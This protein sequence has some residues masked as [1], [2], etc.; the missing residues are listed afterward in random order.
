[1]AH[2]EI[3]TILYL[4]QAINVDKYR[5]KGHGRWTDFFQGWAMR[6]FCQIFS[7]GWPKVVKF[8]F[9]H[10]KLR[11][12]LFLLTFSKSRGSLAPCPSFRWARKGVFV[13]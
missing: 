9:Y 8:V 10:S 1:M 3:N 4:K 5:P 12:Q 13:T 7:S 2:V 11:K 6:G